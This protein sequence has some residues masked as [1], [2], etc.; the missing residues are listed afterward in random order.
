[1]AITTAYVIVWTPG[2]PSSV[3]RVEVANTPETRARGLAGRPSVPSDGGM[4][5][6]FP[7]EEVQTFWMRNTR[8]HLDLVF[9]GS[10]F[11]VREVVANATPLS[12]LPISSGVPVRYVLEVPAGQ[13]AR[14]G[15]ARGVAVTIPI[16]PA[17]Y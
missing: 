8:V 17:G 7:R 13:A 2:S 16:V 9:I 4:L 14:M 10:D 5:F 6:A 3:R 12:T 11:V 15:L 1:M